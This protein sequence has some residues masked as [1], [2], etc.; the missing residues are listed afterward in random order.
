MKFI[1]GVGEAVHSNLPG[2]WFIVHSSSGTPPRH[3]DLAHPNFLTVRERNENH[4]NF[5]ALL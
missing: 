2:F 3:R 4:V 5:K 1:G